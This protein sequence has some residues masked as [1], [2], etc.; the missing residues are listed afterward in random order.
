MVQGLSLAV[1]YDMGKRDGTARR[2]FEIRAEPWKM[3]EG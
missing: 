3:M 2:R 1:W